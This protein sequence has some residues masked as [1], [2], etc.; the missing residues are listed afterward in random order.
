MS[1]V[2]RH[3]LP[4][5]AL[6]LAW[7]YYAGALLLPDSVLYLVDTWCQDV[8]L[9]LDAARVLRDGAFPH[10]NPN[11][12]CGFP[13]HADSQTGVLYPFFLLY[14][15]APTPET[16]DWF[17]ALH[18]LLAGLF[19]YLY[20]SG[21]GAARGRL[22]LWPAS[23][24]GAVTFMAGSYLQ[25][26]HIVPGVLAAACWI[27]LSLW[28]LDRAV[29]GDRRAIWW[30]A[31]VNAISMLAGHLHVSLI[32]FSLQAAYLARLR[33]RQYP[34]HWPLEAGIA[35]VLPIALTA[36]QIVPTLHYVAQSTRAS[37]LDSQLS[38]ELYSSS[39]LVW[40]H[41]LTFF[42]P[43]LFGDP[44][45]Y[46]LEHVL[47][48][49]AMVVFQGYAAIGLIPLAVLFWRPRGDVVFW[50]GILSVALLLAL[51]SPLLKLLYHVPIYNLF[52][53]PAR[54]MLLASLAGAVLAALGA[55]V[56]LEWFARRRMG[57]S[58]GA[59]VLAS[60]VLVALTTAGMHR[61][62]GAFLTT[63]DFYQI[64]PQEVLAAHR[65]STH[66]R[67]LPCARALYQ[68]WRASDE[69]LR[70][71]ARFLPVSYNLLFGVPA[72]TLFD[73][74]NAVTPRAM[75]E[76][77]A[78][79]HPNALRIAAV[80]HVTAPAP[81]DELPPRERL[82]I[83][84]FTLPPPELIEPLPAEEIF[85][86]RFR[87]AMPRA[88]M[89][90]EVGVL[91]EPEDRLARLAS[92]DF[93]PARQALVEQPV[94]IDRAPPQPPQVRVT[95]P[96]PDRLVIDV[97]TAARGLLVV[98]DQYSLGFEVTTDG[99]P[100][101]LLRTNHAFRGVVVPEG[102][103]RVEMTYRPSAFY[104]GLSISVGALLLVVWRLRRAGRAC[105]GRAEQE[106]GTS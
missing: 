95:Q 41:L 47:W 86:G 88:W 26:T 44:W 8:P 1:P 100:A 23:L 40:P 60:V 92:D 66:V 28:L 56:S 18:Y 61:T 103:H 99:Q 20:L 93:D 21:Y 7:A 85:F 49:E 69:Q 68:V 52:R 43:D 5:L 104:L 14:V 24:V 55:Q 31:L 22:L 17:M 42:A 87:G 84:E 11:L 27:P 25:T 106:A 83:E 13:Q 102:R 73:Q 34:R 2:R 71:N 35:F 46:R 82:T 74:G 96:R 53:W 6:L 45:T 37:D 59:A 98:A 57:R 97:E 80:T 54:Y 9:R 63:A 39:P 79:G 19:M 81:L 76:V 51:A 3:A 10:W 67:I 48:E 62:M 105:Q 72:A 36:A 91:P 64:A 75:H 58:R 78:L 50:L 30:C 4:I 65:Q 77:V 38:W 32:G 12:H 33:W 16:H 89:V 94:D 15:L 101:E 90:Y 29:A 70:A